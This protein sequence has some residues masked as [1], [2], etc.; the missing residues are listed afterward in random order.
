VVDWASKL[1]NGNGFSFGGRGAV[2]DTEPMS[3][4]VVGEYRSGCSKLKNWKGFLKPNLEL[5]PS[6][7][8]WGM[9]CCWAPR[10]RGKILRTAIHTYH[11]PSKGVVPGGS[12]YRSCS[13]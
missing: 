12:H 13:C 1:K 5:L 8:G 6:W 3:K 2:T 7:V 4:L 9:G 10:A 11:W